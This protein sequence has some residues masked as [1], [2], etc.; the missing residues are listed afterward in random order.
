[1]FWNSAL[2]RSGR[3][4]AKVKL[5]GKKINKNLGIISYAGMEISK[6][7]SFGVSIRGGN[8]DENGSWMCWVVAEK[9]VIGEKYL[10]DTGENE[11][12]PT[13]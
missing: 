2:N 10:S 8:G 12:G 3:R 13:L 11:L 4:K 1:M 6:I 5:A 9:L 7:I